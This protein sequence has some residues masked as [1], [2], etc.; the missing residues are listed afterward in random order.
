MEKRLVNFSSCVK[1]TSTKINVD[2]IARW[3]EREKN[4]LF[5]HLAFGWERDSQE[6]PLKMIDMIGIHFKTNWL[7]YK[8]ARAFSRNK[9]E[10]C[11][12][13][14]C[15]FFFKKYTQSN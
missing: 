6:E 7:D 2:N 13:Y 3:I 1:E 10:N 5:K 4:L 15:S 8:C 14:Y 12:T 9:E 11:I